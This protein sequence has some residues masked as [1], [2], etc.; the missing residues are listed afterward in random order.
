ML[1]EQI[2]N[3]INAYTNS[4]GINKN[5]EYDSSEQLLKELRELSC[6]TCLLDDTIWCKYCYNS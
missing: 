2:E 3:D 1:E 6:D 4:L 5:K